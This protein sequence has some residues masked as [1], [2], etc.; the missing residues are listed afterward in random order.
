MSFVFN[1]FIPRAYK[2]T[3]NDGG[4][5]AIQQPVAYKLVVPQ[6]G[7]QGVAGPGGETSIA[8]WGIINADGSIGDHEGDFTVEHNDT[9]IYQ[10]TLTTPP[11]KMACVVTVNNATP[12]ISTVQ[13]V[14]SIVTVNIFD[15][16]SSFGLADQ[17]FYFI[18][19]GGVVSTFDGLS[20]IDAPDDVTMEANKAY[21]PS[22]VTQC[23]LALPD[24][25]SLGTRIAIYGYGLGGWKV[26][27]RDGE[28]IQLAGSQNETT[29]G[30]GGF[31]ESAQSNDVAEFINIADKTWLV[32]TF[33]CSFS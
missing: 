11:D 19:T 13:I 33:G 29:A 23:L 15:Y 5:I 26:T 24:N 20:L 28:Q 21:R 2:I 18:V 10:I 4:A 7:P 6:Q 32:K 14:S 9:G 31:L 3:V 17:P 30:A 16:E 25:A 27:Q 22:K 12:F 8:A 1:P